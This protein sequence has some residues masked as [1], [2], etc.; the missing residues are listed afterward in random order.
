[1]KTNQI[2]SIKRFGKYASCSFI[3]NYRQ[4]LLFWGALTFTLIALSIF[5]MRGTYSNWNSDGWEQIF[6]PGFYLGGAIYTGF[7]FPGFRSKERTQTELLIPVSAFER[8][9][10]EFLVK[11]IAFIILFPIIFYISSS[12]AVGISNTLH[13]GTVSAT[14]NGI[15]TFP[16]KTISYA[17]L[18]NPMP[19][20][21]FSM[22]CMLSV[23]VF[24]IAFAGA[25]TFRK[26]PLIKTI[27]IIG[28]IIMT[29]ITYFYLLVQNSVLR[30]SW[31]KYL[32]NTFTQKQVFLLI[33]LIFAFITLVAL[34]Y[35]YFKLKEKEAA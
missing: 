2:F 25:A 32:E 16:Y 18:Y 3:S 35:T 10:Y 8:L 24:V 23:L 4:S 20:G 27:V 6:I 15:E 21:F 17:K 30:N 14:L 13:I 19:Q 5:I 12:L 31:P 9:L 26:L 33:T 28:S 29:G 11:V 34:V 7:A 1:M 22:I